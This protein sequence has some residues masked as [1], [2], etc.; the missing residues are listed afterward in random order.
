MLGTL[1]GSGIAACTI[2]SFSKFKWHDSETKTILQLFYNIDFKVKDKFPSLYKKN[3]NTSYTEYIFKTPIGIKVKNELRTLLEYSL[4]KP[5]DINFKGLLSIKVYNNHLPTKLNYEWRPTRGWV[6]PIG[7]SL[8]G[9]V[10]HNFDEIPHM[11]IAGMTRQGKTVLLKLILAHL[12]NNNYDAEFYVLDLKGGLEFG[13]YERLRHVKCVSSSVGEALET[14]SSLSDKIKVDMELFKRKE[15]NNIVNT[16]IKR[17]RFIIVDE[18]AELDK[19]CQSLLSEIARIGGALGYRLIFATQY[20]TADTL[21]RQIKQNTDARIS[22]RLP[23]EVASRVAL[24]EQGA[25]KLKYA[26]RAIYR[27]H[28][29]QEVQVPYIIDK[30]IMERLDKHVISKQETKQVRK[31]TIEFG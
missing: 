19:R 14:L 27:T 17:R 7:R 25:E 22:F 15:I 1:L 16:K 13:K 30:E 26:G 9:W 28:E 10:H 23:T 11:T 29:R 5:V 8:S 31:D 20:P 12:I 2:Y 4:N 6:V 21:P 24:D 18:A 3:I